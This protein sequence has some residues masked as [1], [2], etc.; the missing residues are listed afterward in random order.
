MASSEEDG[1][2][3]EKENN[4]KK[5]TKSALT[6]AWLTFYNI[7]MTAG[8]LVLA[9]AMLRFYIK[10]GTHKGLYRSIART[11]KFFQTFALLSPAYRVIC[12]LGIVRTSVIVTGVQVCSRIFMVWLVASS[13]RQIQ[14]EESVILFLVV[15]TVTEITRYSYY[16]FKLLNHLPYFVKWARYN[17]FIVL[18]PLGV[19]GEL[20]SIYAALPFVRRSGMYSMRLPNKYNV[21][22][23]YYY[24]LIII[25]VTF[26]P[27]N[28]SWIF[29]LLAVFPQL[30]FHMLRQRRRVLHGEV[31]VEKDD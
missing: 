24:C 22:F 16:T 31:I 3:E 15:W 14:N 25:N 5:R 23:D 13:I 2:V 11:L 7:A 20:L 30:Y 12:L 17:F 9:M 6:T 4:N 8:W 29:V 10:K 18:Y 1:T 28:F 27:L 26:F 19:I 21:S